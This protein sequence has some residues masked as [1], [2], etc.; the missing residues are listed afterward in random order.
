[1][2]SRSD[3]RHR[4]DSCR[5]TRSENYKLQVRQAMSENLEN[6]EKV[7]MYR[8][9]PEV[10]EALL[11]A[12]SECVFNWCTKDSWPVG[13]CMSYIWRDGRVWLT[14]T[15]QRHRISAIKRNPQVSVVVSSMGTD[16]GVR[17]TVT[18]KGTAEVHEDHAA[19]DWF[20]ADFARAK[21]DD[22]EQAASF[23]KG[24]R[25]PLRVVIEVTPV[26]FISHDGVKMEAHLA[27][28]L[29]ESQLSA[30]L[31]SDTVRVEQELQRR[32]N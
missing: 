24:L 15:G 31:E 13:V 14:A 7:S 8:L 26:K 28:N 12:Q 25:S 1:M 30:P 6:Y 3:V 18:I 9:D 21:F 20:F 22:E 17:R 19:V 16:M 2:F 11:L 32:S 27:G 10:Q 29:D 23:E 5:L 4:C